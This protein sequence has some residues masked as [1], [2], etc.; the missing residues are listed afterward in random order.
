MRRISRLH[1]LLVGL[2]S[3]GFALPATATELVFEGSLTVTSLDLP[4]FVDTAVGV[5][6][7]NSSGGGAN[8][9]SLQIP[10]GL[11]AVSTTVTPTTTGAT[12]TALEVNFALEAGSVATPG[13]SP[14]GPLSGQIPVPGNI[15]ICILFSCLVNVDVPLTQGETRGVGIGGPPIMQGGLVNV[16]ATGAPWNDQNA[17]ITTTSSSVFTAM[18]FAH[19]PVSMT[20]STASPSGVLQLVTPVAIRVDAGSPVDVPTFGVLNVKFLPEPGSFLLL[21][22]GAAALALLGA[23]RRR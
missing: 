21:T 9:T 1:R 14:T 2:A 23:R 12:F 10:G 16:T 5:A 13:A 6:T 17:T 20:Q 3:L 22:A 19:G 15:R 8:L 4:G 11:F 7:V 18:G